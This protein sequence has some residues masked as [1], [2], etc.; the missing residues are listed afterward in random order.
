MGL[1][2]TA[3]AIA[4][5]SNGE[6][7]YVANAGDGTVSV[8][9]TS[10][11]TVVGS[12]INVGSGPEAIAIT[13]N[14]AFAYVA[15]AGDGTVSVI[16]TSTNMVVGSPIGVG[17]GPDAIA[18]TPDGEFAYVANT[19]SNNVSVI[20]TASN[21]VIGSI[22]VGSGPDAI[23]ISPNA[24]AITSSLLLPPQNLT[25]HQKKNDFGLVYERFNLLQWTASPSS[26][27]AGYFVYRDGVKIATLDASTF[28]YRDH[29]RRKGV[30]TLYSVTAFNAV[31]N[32]SASANITIK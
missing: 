25:G 27:V 16:N 24:C 28:K 5:T 3:I 13:P 7:A 21:T 9:N 20:S 8:I 30:T 2:P 10:T 29:D 17:S 23:A 6:P 11:N 19:D 26:A 12:P 4:I 18:I 31:G 14:G 32:E 15:N 1:A 22:G